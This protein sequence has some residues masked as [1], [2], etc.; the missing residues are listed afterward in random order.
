MRYAID[1][2]LFMPLVL[3]GLFFAAVGGASL[4]CSAK[5]MEYAGL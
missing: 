3:L 4:K 2:V 5:C 1:L